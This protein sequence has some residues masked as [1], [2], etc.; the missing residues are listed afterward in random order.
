MN[1]TMDK[2]IKK[3]RLRSTQGKTHLML[4]PDLFD[5]EHEPGFRLPIGHKEV[6]DRLAQGKMTKLQ[7][8]ERYEIRRD[9][10][11]IYIRSTS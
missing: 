5:N 6:T 2:E 9:P 4:Q 10:R 1:R 3:L 11:S 8:F 7:A